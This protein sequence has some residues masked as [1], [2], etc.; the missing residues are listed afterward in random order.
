MSPNGNKM[1]FW[2]SSISKVQLKLITAQA[3]DLI[4]KTETIFNFVYDFME[5]IFHPLFG[6]E[7]QS[8]LLSENF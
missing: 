1:Q 8:I 6:L 3:P 7:S 5:N 2:L 4:P